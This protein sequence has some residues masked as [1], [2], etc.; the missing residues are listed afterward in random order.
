MY[1]VTLVT[2]GPPSRHLQE[3][4]KSQKSLKKGIFGGLQKSPKKYPEM[5]KIPKKV[6]KS[7]FL[8]F[9]GYF[10][11]FSADPPK[12]GFETLFC[13]F[14]PGGPG[15]SCKWRLGSQTQGDLLSLES[16]S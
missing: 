9:F 16:T 1:E 7:A 10:W 5:S 4:P 14:G 12:D 3:S 11:H 6:R 13:D 8:D 15:D 2:V